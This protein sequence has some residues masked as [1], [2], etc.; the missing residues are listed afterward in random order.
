[1]AIV[2][3]Q[4]IT[5]QF[6]TQ[7]VLEDVSFDLHAGE[8][9]GLYGANGSGKTTLFRLIAQEFKPDIGKITRAKN[10]LIGY[11]TQEPEYNP[12]NTLHEEVGSVFD[13]V[14]ALETRLHDLSDQMAHKHA[15]PDLP[16]L[17]ADYDK[18]NTQFIAAGGHQFETR[19]GEI[20][21]G[22]GFTK[23][24]HVKPMSILSSG[25]RCRAALAKVLLEDKPFLLLD[26]P[27]NHLDI[28]TVRWLEKYLEGHRGGA[29]IISH[30]RYLLDH[31]CNRIIEI[32]HRR[33]ASYPGNYTNFANIKAIQLLTEQRQFEKDKTFIDK[34]EAYIAKHLAGQRTRQAKGRRKRLERRMGAGEFVT[35]KTAKQR[36]TKINFDKTTTT[37]STIL[38]CDELRMNYGDHVLFNDLTFQIYNGERFAITGPNGTGKSTLLKIII[39][40]LKPTAGTITLASKLNIG[41]YSQQPTHLD[42]ER[43]VLD[44]IRSVRPEFSE[45]D[46]R[47]FL[48]QFLFSGDDVFKTLGTLSGGEVSRVRLASLILSSPDLLILDEPTNH[49]DIPSCEA[50]EEALIDYCGTIIVVSH[51]RYFLDRI[52]QK[53]LVMKPDTQ[54]LYAGNYSFYIEQLD[55]N[56]LDTQKKRVQPMRKSIRKKK[57]SS[58]TKSRTSPYDHLSIDELERMVMNL[59]TRQSVLRE[60]FGDPDVCKNPEALAQLQTEFDAVTAE[61]IEV[62]EAWQDRADTH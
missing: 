53:L 59:E 32:A 34:E 57:S 42:F 33:V 41:Y 24:D 9:V 39:E 8:T 3:I 47:S 14:L 61:L 62:D 43:T 10:L 1:M 4:G 51:D 16:A 45:Q 25:Q 11:L 35:Q 19:L 28:D 21:S 15:D 18:V 48:G 44:E 30:D 12:S 17:M 7:V 54:A 6:G 5:I 26:E 2:T 31:L 36:T 23:A 38:R 49:L 50:L 20:L 55:Q 37:E 60:R 58:T 22:L 40:E 46:A 29:V 56:R 52:A 13:S 27:T